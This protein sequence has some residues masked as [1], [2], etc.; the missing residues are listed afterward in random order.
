MLLFKDVSSEWR[1]C[2]PYFLIL[3]NTRASKI[4]ISKFLASVLQLTA[5]SQFATV[6]KK[7]AH[8]VDVGF[9]MVVFSLHFSVYIAN[10]PTYSLMPPMVRNS[11]TSG[12]SKRTIKF[13]YLAKCGT[14]VITIVLRQS[15]MGL[16]GSSESYSLV[17][18]MLASCVGFPSLPWP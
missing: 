13:T 12:F 6:E 2:F 17:L 10:H 7:K 14:D 15:R 11:L 16:A 9:W 1:Q 5:S 4:V 8:S 3:K 18:L